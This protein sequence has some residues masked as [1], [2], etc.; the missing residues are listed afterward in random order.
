[1]SEYPQEYN[2]AQYIKWHEQYI[3]K[4]ISLENEIDNILLNLKEQNKDRL[5]KLAEL[6][7]RTHSFL[8]LASRM[9][10]EDVSDCNTEIQL[11]ENLH[12]N[13]D[14]LFK[15]KESILDKMWR[16][17]KDRKQGNEIT[18]TNIK[19]EMGDLIRSSIV[20]STFAYA[21]NLASSIGLW[22]ELIDTLQLNKDH[23]QDLLSID[24]QHEAKMDKGY[25]AYHLDVR[26]KDG[27]R[28]EIQIYSKLSQVWRSLSHKLYEKVRLGEDVKWGHGAAASRLVSLGHLLH[29]AECE[30]QHL[31]S[32]ISD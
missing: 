1:M 24:T 18:T 2:Q 7:S 31:K 5:A 23:Y 29:L 17:N 4:D 15:S 26:Y 10:K 16:K 28:V 6:L 14:L 22:E 21:D 32:T 8:L 27:L 25:F 3:E 9:K 11:Q 12:Q 13:Y 30:V 19:D 20:T